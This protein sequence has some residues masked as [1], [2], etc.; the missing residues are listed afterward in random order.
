MSV[1]V[2]DFVLMNYPSSPF[3]G[4]IG[5]VV[6][7]FESAL[8]HVNVTYNSRDRSVFTCADYLTVVNDVLKVGA[9]LISRSGDIYDIV[10]I[11]YKNGTVYY[12]SPD[13][14]CV[15]ELERDS[16]FL[17]DH[18]FYKPDFSKK[19]SNSDTN[20][21]SSDIPNC[22]NHNEQLE[23]KAQFHVVNWDCGEM[24]MIDSSSKTL[25]QAFKVAEVW[26][27]KNA[28][29]MVMVYQLKATAVSKVFQSL[30]VV[31]Y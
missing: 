2:G 3:F 10:H 4:R 5:I 12:V 22:V 7:T 27:G 24:L 21:G 8:P 23:E 14:D 26:A 31:R 9:K 19:C 11:H 30:E 18:T 29:K 15:Y 20:S 13:R 16:L 28:G 17:H 25:E 1:K 6:K